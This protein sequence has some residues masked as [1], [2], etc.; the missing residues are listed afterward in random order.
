MSREKKEIK[1]VRK[2]ILILIIFIVSM[3]NFIA[4]A[5]W[6]D[7]TMGVN[8]REFYSIDASGENIYL[9]TSGG[10]YSLAE[11]DNVWNPVF[12]CRGEM[13]GVKH[14]S[15]LSG[16]IVYIATGNG[17][18]YSNNSGE[19]WSRVFHGI[20]E[21]NY[22]TYVLCKNDKTIYL[23]TMKGLF[24]TN[25]GGET[26]KK[27]L[28]VL[29][30]SIIK[31]IAISDL[32]DNS[33]FVVGNNEVYKASSD[34]S[35]YSKIFGSESFDRVEVEQIGEENLEEE[36][37][38]LIKDIATSGEKVYIA[39]NKGLFFSE[40][41]GIAW[42][43]FNRTGLLT[44]SI[45]YVIPKK[46]MGY[47]IL[48]G[49]D[50]GVYGYFR[51]RSFWDALY[52]GMDSTDIRG[53]SLSSSGNIWALSNDRIYTVNLEPD[54]KSSNSQDIMK[55]FTNEPTVNETMEMAIMYAEVYPEKIKRWRQGAKY[56]A[57]LPRVSI[58]ID[59]SWSDTYEI[60]TSSSSQYWTY[61]PQDRSEGWD[62]NLTW[63]LGDLIWNNAQ[64]SID[65]RSKL[66]VQLRDDIVDEITRTF[67]ERRRLQIELIM[68]PPKD[69][70]DF[71]QKH[72]RIQ[73]LTAS[74]DG[75]TGGGF[76]ENTT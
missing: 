26:W 14:I 21:E 42:S 33:V 25:D 1:M 38:F 52:E 68:S 29:G 56:K 22:C 5:A 55:R 34:F 2:S 76:S 37:M 67:F 19:D 57:I 3:H 43:R 6:Q 11:K 50:K 10:L 64:T 47:E 27:P 59:H 48:L 49:T 30:D 60:Y 20:D 36:S 70:K 13:K 54:D 46:I 44:R 73:E 71:L 41:G 9:G 31:S 12:S 35:D 62:I 58:G 61:G 53:L 66:M 74:L 51:N 18:Y 28:G 24:W 72:L 7:K 65:V 17:L 69:R 39:T 40:D 45:K 23:C 8:D 16:G 32:T 75:L 4:Y 63:D 15:S